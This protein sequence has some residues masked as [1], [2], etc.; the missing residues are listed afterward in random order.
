[1]RGTS[2][3][4]S[5]PV[6]AQFRV[7]PVR[8]EH[9][10]GI[11]EVACL[12]HGF[13]LGSRACANA[14]HIAQIIERFP[15]GQFVVV[16]DMPEG[17]ER[18]IG[19]A[20][21]MRTKYLPSSRPLSWME[22]VGGLNLAFH[23][24]AGQWLYGVDK[25]VHPDFQGRGVATALYKAQFGL[26]ERLGLSGMYAGGMLKG[27]GIYR[28]QMSVREYAARVLHGEIFDP[29]VSVQIK[30]GFK[31]Y[32]VIENYAW[33]PQ[34]EHTGMLIVWERPVAPQPRSEG[35]GL[36]LRARK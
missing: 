35:K 33:D 18:V 23:D 26:V 12:A 28:E 25:A 3:S 10:Q 11:H 19:M 6:S 17:K 14:D 36:E 9:G 4:T 24:P 1:M 34:A 30:R 21:A 20:L 16:T 32:G 22:M 29:T 2:S 7:V 27:Y 13:P 15:E 5:S 31:P 8:P